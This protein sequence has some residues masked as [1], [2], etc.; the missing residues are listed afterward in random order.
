MKEIANDRNLIA[1][2][3]LYCGTC[4]KYLKEK[5]P[6][7]ARN[8]KAKWCK[9]RSCCIE[10][11][12][13][14]CADCKTFKSAADCGKFSNLISRILA[15]IYGSNRPAAIALIKEKGYDAFAAYMTQNKL[16]T[17]KR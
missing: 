3:G 7:C 11:K 2:C 12:L 10:N 1:F 6:G 8:E 15:L 13:L 5:C 9:I 16:L 17:M 14:S 4:G